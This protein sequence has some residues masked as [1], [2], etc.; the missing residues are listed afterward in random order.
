[1][2]A[3]TPSGSRLRDELEPLHREMREAIARV[4]AQARGVDGVLRVD[5]LGPGRAS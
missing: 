2:V 1:M 4:M 5:F 3:L